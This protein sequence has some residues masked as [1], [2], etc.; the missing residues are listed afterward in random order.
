MF[1]KELLIRFTVHGV[2]ERLWINVVS[3]D[4]PIY[5]CVYASL[6]LVSMV[7]CGF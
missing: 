1:G 2:Y 3:I 7:E 6:D 5:S 4:F